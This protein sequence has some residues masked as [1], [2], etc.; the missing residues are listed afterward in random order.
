MFEALLGVLRGRELNSTED[1]AGRRAIAGD[2]ILL[3]NAQQKLALQYFEAHAYI[4]IL[5][6]DEYKLF[7]SIAIVRTNV[8]ARVQCKQ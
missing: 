7:I 3:Q 6:A 1:V 8:L 2:A 4:Y 5:H